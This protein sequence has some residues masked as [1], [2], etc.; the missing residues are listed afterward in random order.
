MGC[1]NRR[2]RSMSLRVASRTEKSGRC[3]SGADLFI[4][5]VADDAVGF[6]GA[7]L[8]Y[9]IRQLAVAN[10]SAAPSSIPQLELAT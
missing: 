4:A 9:R 8:S 3:L 2:P 1:A 7:E 6:E 10:S 5:M